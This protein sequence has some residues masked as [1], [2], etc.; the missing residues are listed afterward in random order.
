MKTQHIV[1]DIF[2]L[3]YLKK[4]KVGKL[5]KIIENKRVNVIKLLFC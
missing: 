5:Q 3:D 4:K 1:H 2:L